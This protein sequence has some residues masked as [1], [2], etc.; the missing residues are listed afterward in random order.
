[1]RIGGEGII[2]QEHGDWRLESRRVRFWSRPSADG[3]P[4]MTMAY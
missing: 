1:M 4:R 3:L 2:G